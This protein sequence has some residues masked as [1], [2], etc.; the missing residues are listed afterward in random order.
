M[1]KITAMTRSVKCEKQMTCARYVLLYSG[2]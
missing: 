1:V 2:L